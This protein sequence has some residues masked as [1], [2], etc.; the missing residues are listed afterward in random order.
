MTS[1]VRYNESKFSKL[2]TASKTATA[3]TGRISI[4]DIIDDELNH[5]PNKTLKRKADD[6]AD[7]IEDEVNNW[8]SLSSSKN[9]QGL[10]EASDP[11]AGKSQIVGKSS[12]ATISAGS[13]QRPVKRARKFVE[14]L[15]YMAVGGAAVGASVFFG[16]VAT[17]PDFL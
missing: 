10:T 1:S 13:G 4:F 8:S 5:T 6:I 3:S 17:A 14:R 16:L 9:P 12:L 15:G 11:Q 2:A 7:V